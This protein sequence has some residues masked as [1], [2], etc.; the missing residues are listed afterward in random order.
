MDLPSKNLL[1]KSASK[2]S[3]DEKICTTAPN[4]D[5]ETG[6]HSSQFE[7]SN[8]IVKS[9]R[10]IGSQT[11]TKPIRNSSL[12]DEKSFLKLTET[13]NK[14][15]NN[16]SLPKQNSTNSLKAQDS[17]DTPFQIVKNRRKSKKQHYGL[18]NVLERNCQDDGN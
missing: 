8:C 10:I 12:P 16:N 15:E 4:V 18:S 9:S 5:S 6:Y 7:E 1:I 2:K 3:I 11:E 17:Q 14:P 13:N